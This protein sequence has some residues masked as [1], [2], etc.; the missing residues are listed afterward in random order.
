MKNLKLLII[1]FILESCANMVIPTGGKKDEVIPVIRSNN[2]TPLNFNEKI[3]K[4]TFEEY[5]TLNEPNKNISIQ[6]NHT[7]FKTE[8]IGKSLIIKFDSILHQNTTYSLN[9]DK[10]IK[11]VNE[12]NNFSYKY[13][14]STGNYRDTNYIEYSIENINQLTDLKIGLNN[15][16]V[17]SLPKIKFDYI[18]NIQTK[19]IRIDGLKDMPYNVWIFIDKNNDLIPDEYKPIYYDTSEINNIKNIELNKWIKSDNITTKKYNR[20]TKIYKSIN[21]LSTYSPLSNYVY[22]DKDSSLF[23]DNNNDTLPVLKLKP[24][25]LNKLTN[26]IVAINNNKEYNIIIDKC[27]IR[28]LQI[29][30]QLKYTEDNNYFYIT[31]KSK[32]DSINLNFIHSIDSFQFTVKIQ[33]Y[34]ESNKLSV[35][36]LNKLLKN[37]TII[38]VLYK[39]DK[40]QLEKKLILNKDLIFYL[41]PGNYKVEFYKT[42]LF[43]NLSFNYQKLRRISTPIIKKEILIK[44]NWDEVLQLVF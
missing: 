4:I 1:L 41:Q 29:I 39:D 28:N 6:P 9:I 14:F 32:L 35:L 25:I 44:P 24:E 12:G 36:K 38:M 8:L 15:A 17:D 5:I 11:D 20:F 31:S 10:G 43:Q 27:G 21:D 42:N 30:D 22:I 16:Y 33:Q 23:Y 7:T 19:Q 18:Y 3:I 13:I 40:I 34:I 2:L 26:K 37:D